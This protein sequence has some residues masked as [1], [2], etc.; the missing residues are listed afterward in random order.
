MGMPTATWPKWQMRSMRPEL[1]K[2]H[3]YIPFSVDTNALL[4]PEPSS[5]IDLLVKLHRQLIHI[6]ILLL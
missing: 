4:I 5:D 3:L 2:T 1:Q 6:L